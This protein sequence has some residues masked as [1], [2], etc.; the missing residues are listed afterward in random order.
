MVQRNQIS[1]RG[2][3]SLRVHSL[4]VRNL[5]SPYREVLE[6]EVERL[7]KRDDVLA[8]GLAGSVSREDFWH[9]ADLDIEV[10]LVGDKPKNL[11]CTE[12]EI[13][14]DFGYFGESQIDDLPHDTRPIYDPTRVLANTLRKRTKRQLWQRMIQKNTDS[15]ER[16]LQKARSALRSDPYSALCH[17]QNGGAGLGSNLVL[18]TGTAP[19]IRRTISKLEAAMSKIRRSDL[20]DEYVSLYGMPEILE[21]TDFLCEQLKQGYREVWSYMNEKAVGPAYMVQQS[22]SEPWF[23]NRIQPIFEHDKRDLV[24]IVLI[25][26]PFILRFIFNTIG[27]DD[28]PER[29]F[30]PFINLSGPPTYWVNRYRRILNFVPKNSVPDLLST[31][32]KLNAEVKKLAGQKH[33]S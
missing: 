24:W 26:Y 31:A 6:R 13:S 20:F 8:I 12:Q 3:S 25:E 17:I 16:Y 5:P 11:V 14:V 22:S 32:E 33:L 23:R 15:A 19:S 4:N 28:F 29:V 2:A 18:A 21:K 27:I 7:K 10:V 1:A 30:D 9:G